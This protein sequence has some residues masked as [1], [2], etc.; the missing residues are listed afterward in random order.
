[1]M[2]VGVIGGSGFLGMNILRHLTKK[3]NFQLSATSR[4]S[5]EELKLIPAQWEVLDLNQSESI[6]PFLEKLDAVVYLAHEGG[7]NV[8]KNWQDESDQNLTPIQNFIEALRALRRPTPLKVI[9]LSSG[10]AIYGNSTTKIPWKETDPPMP[11]SPYGVL[12]QTLE[13]R[14][15]LASLEKLCDCICLRVSNPYGNYFKHQKD[16]GMI[17]VAISKLKSKEAFTLY[18]SS[19]YVRDF[20]HIDDLTAAIEQCLT[21]QTSFDIFNIGSGTGTSVGS[22]LSMLQDAFHQTLTIKKVPMSPK[23]IPVDWCVLDVSKARALLN[24]IP[25]TS[26]NEALAAIQ[27]STQNYP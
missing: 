14:L 13:N 26:L 27:G 21:H 17:D 9:Y 15:R 6:T 19:Q 8:V 22:A 25:K 5:K 11:V 16:Q 20:I 18:G 23:I 1:M 24:W 7:P 4:E 12:K 10:G 2:R 3:S